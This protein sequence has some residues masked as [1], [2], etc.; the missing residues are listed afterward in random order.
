MP[1]ALSILG[2]L[3]LRL[4]LH[5]LPERDWAVLRLAR[6]G[7]ARTGALG[8]LVLGPDAPPFSRQWARVTVGEVAHFGLGVLGGLVLWAMAPGG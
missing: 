3:F 7:P 8:L 2:I 5:K 1:L 4:A 6:A